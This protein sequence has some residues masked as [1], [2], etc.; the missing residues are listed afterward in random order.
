MF[1]QPKHVNQIIIFLIKINL[2]LNRKQNRRYPDINVGDNLKIYKKKKIF[3]MEY[4]SA[5]LPGN[6]QVEELITKLGQTFYK[7]SNF[8]KLLSRHEVL[9]NFIKYLN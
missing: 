6:H 7:V 3:G 5:W 4:K 8:N 2:K 9:K 1:H